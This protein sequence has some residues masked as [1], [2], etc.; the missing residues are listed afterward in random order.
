[1]KR[2]TKKGMSRN[3]RKRKETRNKEGKER[4]HCKAKAMQV[5]KKYVMKE[6]REERL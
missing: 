4:K 3:G 1:M 6:G 5:E 2:A